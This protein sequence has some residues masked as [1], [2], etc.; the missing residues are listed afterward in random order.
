MFDL[1]LFQEYPIFY[2]TAIIGG[3]LSGS[4]P[5]GLI[6]TAL[7]GKGDIRKIGS[8]N[9]GA[10]N[11]LRT[12]SKI[13]AILTLILDMAKG[14]VPAA[15]A[16]Y[17]G[18]EGQL[19]LDAD[20]NDIFVATGL[21]LALFTSIFA[22]LGHMYSPWLKFKGGKGVATAIGSLLGFNPM[23]ALAVIL[24]WL[25]SAIS[26]RLSSLAA[27][28]AFAAAPFYAYFLAKSGATP[29]EQAISIAIISLFI[30]WKHRSNIKRLIKN[31]EPKIGKKS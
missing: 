4:I 9:I 28:I 13:L 25:V 2:L 23:L 24:T 14:G 21:Q 27:L 1:S 15:I 7:A 5:Y 22:V 12:G 11:V 31:K 6:L 8:G 18:G 17:F 19:T 30:F 3:F 26:C 10:T 29:T 16:L 20:F